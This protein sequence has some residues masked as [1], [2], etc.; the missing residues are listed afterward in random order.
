M[1]TAVLCSVGSHV[2]HVPGMPVV[3]IFSVVVV[4]TSVVP[5]TECVVG[6]SDV[7]VDS[8]L[9]ALTELSERIQPLNACTSTIQADDLVPRSSINL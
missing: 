4:W 6:A 3:V 8:A 5:V 9:C 2:G 7:G 1:A